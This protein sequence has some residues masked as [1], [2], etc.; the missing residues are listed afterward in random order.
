MQAEG[1]IERKYAL[2]KIKP[3]DYFLPSN[4]GRTLWRITSYEDGPSSGLDWPRDRTLW[5]LW[6]WEGDPALFEAG[7]LATIELAI[8]DWDRWATEESS[9]ET[10]RDAIRQAHKPSQRTRRCVVSK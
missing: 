4:D 8:E 5:Q 9:L 1:T 3:G 2:I 6:R 7:D 10:R